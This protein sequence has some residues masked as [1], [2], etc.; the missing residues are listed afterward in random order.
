MN[1]HITEAP[2][3]NTRNSLRR[4]PSV[5]HIP[6]PFASDIIIKIKR[7]MYLSSRNTQEIQNRWDQ[8]T[9][10]RRIHNEIAEV[11]TDKKRKI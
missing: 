10:R 4:K 6:E 7:A 8:R 3:N 9:Q 11:L 2:I 1:A 5:I